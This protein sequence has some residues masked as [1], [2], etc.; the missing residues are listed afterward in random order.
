MIDPRWIE[1]Q[2]P[3]APAVRALITTRAGGYSQGPWGDVSG[4]NG[5]NLGLGSDD[6]ATVE[7]NRQR[8]AALL[9]AT[10]VWLQQVHGSTVVD[11]ARYAPGAQADGAVTC[12]PGVVCCV[13]VA[14]C[15]PVL[16]ADTLG[17]GVGI[18]H[19]G[20]RGLAGGVIQTA[21]A[22]LRGLV[23][24]PRAR[25]LAFLGP[26]IGPGQFVV[27]PEVRE[28]MCRTLAMAPQAF[29]E[30][31]PDRYRAN[32]YA[33]ARMALAQEGVE[34]VYGGD[35]CT[36]SDPERFYSFR[37]DRV[38]GRQAALIWMEKLGNRE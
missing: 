30:H 4:R 20:W 35:W 25:T 9:P 6:A 36:V 14:D 16:L 22:Q 15:L 10:P 12:E 28:A 11:A 18:A 23:G 31:P 5:L 3:V 2:W 8:L 29:V 34:A 33:L 1:P 21:V 19:A 24:D 7:R 26:A 27:G 32:L 13:L 37:R 38:T 17:R